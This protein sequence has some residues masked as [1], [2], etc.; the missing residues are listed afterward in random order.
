MR[1]VPGTWML[2]D[3]LMW[4]VQLAGRVSTLITQVNVSVIPLQ[5][6]VRFLC[7]YGFKHLHN[8]P[9]TCAV[10]VPPD[11]VL[12]AAHFTCASCFP[13]I[14]L[15]PACVIAQS[16]VELLQFSSSQVSLHLF[17]VKTEV[18]F[19]SLHIVLEFLSWVICVCL[20]SAPCSLCVREYKSTSTV[21][22]QRSILSQEFTGHAQHLMSLT[23]DML[24]V[25]LVTQC[26]H[27]SKC[28]CKQFNQFW[29][30]VN[31]E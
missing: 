19:L 30:T 22:L 29:V 21:E 23:H 27:P 3:S 20:L 26:L 10:S 11:I 4:W 17:P 7:F 14:H 8:E 31:A 5:M 28:Q 24:P 18:V 9:Q 12:H 13:V 25:F 15:Y 6:S 2:Q 16:S 1:T